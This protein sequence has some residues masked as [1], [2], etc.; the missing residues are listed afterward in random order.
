MDALGVR[1]VL[2]RSSEAQGKVERSIRSLWQQFEHG[3]AIRHHH[4]YTLYQADYNALLHQHMLRAMQQPH[5]VQQR[6]SREHVYRTSLVQH[7]P[8]QV[9]TDI[10][11]LATQV[12]ERTVNAYGCISLNG[13]HYQV[14]QRV[15]G[16]V[17][18]TGTRVR[19]YRNAHGEVIG[20]LTERAHKGRFTCSPWKATSYGSFA[21]TPTQTLSERLRRQTD[22]RQPLAEALG[23]RVQFLPPRP[24]TITPDSPH[25]PVTPDVPRMSFLDAAAR[26]GHALRAL[27]L[28]NGDVGPII[29]SLRERGLLVEQMPAD[30]VQA[31]IENIL[32]SARMTGS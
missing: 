10:V 1:L 29:Q 3:L 11:A 12:A 23:G 6:H 16:Y 30:D 7:P 32:T 8:R 14:P 31:I 18:D 9:E 24:A 2:A 21:G 25:T 20:E 26:V 5:P 17:V 13:H 27:G 4:G 28:D 19:V 15:D 22:V